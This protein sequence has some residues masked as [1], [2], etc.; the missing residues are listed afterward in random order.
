MAPRRRVVHS[1][2]ACIADRGCRRAGWGVAKVS[3]LAAGS[4]STLA[5]IADLIRSMGTCR[6]GIVARDRNI[7]ASIGVQVRRRSAASVAVSIGD[8]GRK[9]LLVRAWEADSVAIAGFSSIAAPGHSLEPCAMEITAAVRSLSASSRVVVVYTG[10]PDL[11]RRTGSTCT[12]HSQAC[13]AEITDVGH[14]HAMAGLI[15]HLQDRVVNVLH[16]G[17]RPHSCSKGEAESRETAACEVL[18]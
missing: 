13:T 15:R 12:R 11:N 7:L 6:G 18:G 4:R 3:D 1:M 17:L 8:Q 16:R 9:S 2:G 5:N 14:L 10:A